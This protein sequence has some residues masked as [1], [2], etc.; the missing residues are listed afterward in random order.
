MKVVRLFRILMATENLRP[1]LS[2]RALLK[3]GISST[4]ADSV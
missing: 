4:R 3:P 1:A 2:K